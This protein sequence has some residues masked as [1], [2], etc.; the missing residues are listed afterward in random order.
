MFTSLIR[1][2]LSFVIAPATRKKAALEMSPGIVMS[3]EKSSFPGVTVTVF[4]SET[5]SAPK[6]ESMSSVWS[7]DLVGSMMMVFS[8]A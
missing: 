4:P 6:E 5:I 3:W 7:L 2:S 8:E 1:I